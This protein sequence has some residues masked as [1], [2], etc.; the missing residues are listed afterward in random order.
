[1]KLVELFETGLVRK[2]DKVII[3]FVTASR[4]E[5]VR[6]G[7]WFSDGIFEKHNAEV[8][9]INYDALIGEWRITLEPEGKP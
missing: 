5:E 1:M 6:R 7:L 2:N 9:S 4:I 3:R 8:L